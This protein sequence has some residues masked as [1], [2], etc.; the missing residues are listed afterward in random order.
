[1]SGFIKSASNPQRKNSAT[2]AGLR[3]EATEYGEP[4]ELPPE[5]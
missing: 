2:L 4:V 5:Q 1:M 3:A